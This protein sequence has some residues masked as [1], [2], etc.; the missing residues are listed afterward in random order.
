MKTAVLLFAFCAGFANAEPGKTIEGAN[1]NCPPGATDLVP[2]AFPRSNY[3]LSGEV[4]K[5]IVPESF[6]LTDVSLT[7][8]VTKKEGTKSIASG[9]AIAWIEEERVEMRGASEK[10]NQTVEKNSKEMQIRAPEIIFDSKM[11]SLECAGLV[12][13]TISGRTIKGRDIKVELGAIQATCF[14]QEFEH[15][16]AIDLSNKPPQGTPVEVP[17]PVTEPATQRP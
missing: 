6:Q 17:P 10:K 14:L 12:E 11:N 9:P 7:G 5:D 16:K 1:K 2:E 8:K 15:A 13:I 3:S 4:V